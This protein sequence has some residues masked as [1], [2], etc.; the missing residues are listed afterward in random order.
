LHSPILRGTHADPNDALID[1]GDIN[2]L[3]QM[4]SRPKDE[5]ASQLPDTPYKNPYDPRND[6]SVAAELQ[7]SQPQLPAGGRKLRSPLLAGEEFDE[8]EFEEPPAQ[9]QPGGRGLRSPM[10][11]GAGG[12][13]ANEGHL[14][15]PLLGAAAGDYDQ[16]SDAPGG[17]HLR[18]PLLGG[19]FTGAE[20]RQ[21]P[22]DTPYAGQERRRGLR[23]PILGGADDYF[24]E[25]P[26]Y[27]DEEEPYDEENP[28]V[29]RS[30]LLAAKR[31]LMDRPSVKAPRDS[32][33]QNP[34]RPPQSP[35]AMP[36]SA[37]RGN[38]NSSYTSLRSIGAATGA[39]QAAAAPPAPEAQPNA[40]TAPNAMAPPAAGVAPPSAVSPP[41][42]QQQNSDPALNQ[43]TYGQPTAPYGQPPSQP[44]PAAAGSGSGYRFGLDQAPTT[45]PPAFQNMSGNQPMPSAVVPATPSSGI[46]PLAGRPLPFGTQVDDTSD[47]NI[48]VLPPGTRGASRSGEHAVSAP[49]TAGGEGQAMPSKGRSRMLAGGYTDDEAD[50]EP[51]GGYQRFAP[52]DQPASPL[53]KIAGAVAAVLLLGKLWTAL[54]IAQQMAQYGPA[55]MADQV[56]GVLALVCLIVFAFT[57]R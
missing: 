9:P 53:P 2:R 27:Y 25:S 7:Q 55:W 41:Y 33:V 56:I 20:R 11:G 5:P 8:A 28:N 46:A 17:A 32:N 38:P 24:D 57:S 18:S 37:S 54:T 19:G 29:L 51:A 45:V 34:A 22:P 4:A 26:E 6:P 10:L 1:G 52:P 43:L 12:G 16:G 21:A 3:R 42:G 35:D 23:S 44:G 36:F 49:G 15:S 31:P 40:D 30:P 14:R 47:S 48:T 13:G 39:Q 50:S